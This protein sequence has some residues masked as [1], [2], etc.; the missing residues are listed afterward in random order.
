MELDWVLDIMEIK[1][2]DKIT[3]AFCGAVIPVSEEY[4]KELI[5]E[6]PGRELFSIFC[7]CRGSRRERE[8]GE[9]EIR[10]KCT[11]EVQQR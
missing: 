7:K 8:P 3:C 1:I 5:R 10:L 11:V 9:A 2:P 4:I 6:H